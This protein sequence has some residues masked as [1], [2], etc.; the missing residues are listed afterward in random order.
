MKG[1]KSYTTVIVGSR[2][3]R[4]TFYTPQEAVNFGAL[5][6]Y[7]GPNDRERVLTSLTSGRNASWTYGFNEVGV[8]IFPAKG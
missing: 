2:G 7:L 5:S 3:G 8:E 6:L 1:S 4:H